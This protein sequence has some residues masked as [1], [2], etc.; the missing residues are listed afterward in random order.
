MPSRDAKYTPALC[1][2]AHGF[3]LNATVRNG[4]AKCKKLKR[5]C[6]YITRPAIAN[7]QQLWRNATYWYGSLCKALHSDPYA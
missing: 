2:D 5:L 4:A 6:R 7:E 3:R 1:A